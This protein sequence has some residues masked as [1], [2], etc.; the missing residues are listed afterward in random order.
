[1]ATEVDHQR[2]AFARE[3][4]QLF[5]KAFTNLK[6]FPHTHQHCRTAVDAFAS[7]LRS[8]VAMYDTLRVGITQDNMLVE[9]QPI[10]E[11]ENRNENLAFRLYVDGLREI[12]IS[13]GVTAEEATRLAHVFYQAIV[14]T[15]L[16]S[17]LLLWE[18]EF[19][20]IDY[21]AINSLS[22]AWAQPD[23]LSQDALKLLKDMN[24][25]VEDIVASL[26]A[27]GARNT[28]EFELSDGASELEKAKELDTAGEDREEG[29]DIFEVNKD[30]LDALRREVAAWGPDRT[31]KHMVE[32]ALDGMALTP[33][34]V[35]RQHVEWLLKEA[36][37]TSIRTKNLDLLGAIATRLQ[38]ELQLTEEEEDEA[39]FKGLFAHLGDDATVVRLIEIAQGGAVGG[40]KAYTRILGMLG[41]SG[42]KAAVSTFKVS[43]TKELG[44]ALQAFILENISRAP[45]LLLP[46]VE[47]ESTPELVRAGLFVAGKK[48]KG[49][50][51]EEVLNRARR[52]PDKKIVEYA[53]H[54]WRTTTDEG[55]LVTM[56]EALEQSESK[57]D[58]MNAVAHLVKAGHRPSIDVLKRVIDAA[59]FLTRDADEKEAFIDGLRRLAGKAAIAFL[60]TQV[61]RSG[62][63]FNRKAVGEVREAAQKALDAI[64]TGK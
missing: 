4:I 9:E 52:H 29:E 13:K 5:V 8:Y 28:Y 33:D 24:K 25:N 11:E 44:E 42:L 32:A 26:T 1:M 43:K 7:R 56:S 41:D 12:A 45:K 50:D 16:D 61:A 18:S 49:K 10:Y 60:Q 46:L 34:L 55:R 51:L 3:V 58:R 6:L 35:A 36:I 62:G 40:P 22:E 37:D 54:Q 39:L 38:G 59:A 20:A 31:L 21:V 23:Y 57:A 53:T 63:L 64:K 30:A 15:K 19:K 27:P 47:P 17:T 14:D 2:I 48:L